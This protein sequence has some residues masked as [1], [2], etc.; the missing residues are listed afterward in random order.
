LTD[1]RVKQIK[2]ASDIVDVVGS[3]INLRPAGP[4]YKGLCPFHDDHRPSLVVDPRWQNYK[5]WACDKYGDVIQFVQEFERV[6]FKEALELLARRA[7]ITL[8]KSTSDAQNLGRA[9]MLDVVRWAA[10]Q[11][12]ECL[13]DSSL[14]EDARRYLG[15]RN[16]KGETVRK[17]ELGFAPRTGDWLV[18]KAEAAKIDPDVL[19]KVSL[20]ARR[21]EGPGFYDR[22]RDRVQFPIR[23]VRGRI[24]GFG[25]RVLPSSPLSERGP[26]YYN[27]SDTPLFSKSELLYGLDQAKAAA[28]KAGYLAV[29]EGYT[30]VL[31][32]HQAGIGQVVA[33]MGTALNAHHVQNL[34]RFAPRVVLVFDA[35]AGGQTGVDRALEIFAG[36]D[37]DLAIATLPA[38][39]D[40]CDLLVQQGPDPFRQ[41]LEKAE[42]ALDFKLR[43]LLNGDSDRGVEGQRRA[44]D[45]VLGIIALAP[46]LP[47]QA[48]A[49]RTQLMVTR[50]SSRLAIREETV[51][52]RLEEMRAQK[53]PVEKSSRA[54]PQ[55][56]APPARS[57]KAVPEERELL[58][59]LLTEEALVAEA[60]ASIQPDEIQ[61]PGLRRLL[62][63]LYALLAEGVP[64][65]L[66]QLRARLL[67]GGDDGPLAQYALNMQEVGLQNDNRA[68][69]FRRLL[70]RFQER[71]NRSAKQKLQ[72][73]LQSTRDH[74][75][76]LDLL[77]RQQLEQHRS[78]E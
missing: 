20:I 21:T 55:V 49:V 4:T 70:V 2:E 40:P 18:R 78:D 5:C 57:S 23:D 42:D 46:P 53:R 17:Y 69:W 59:V 38:G 54:R 30:D 52:A 11:Y 58:E 73:Q 45:A 37:V 16:L 62:V 60:A 34:R 39:L 41:V 1:D 10:Q 76:A 22:F 3:Y 26:K 68:E 14:A 35:D 63:G 64:P 31:M 24:V 65:N 72:T 74:Q 61:H 43:H 32:A 36:Q 71:R 25:G 50:I 15:E 48:G 7:G 19:E 9:L 8:E 66:D 77:R 12:H 27:S 51:W 56:S 33:T 75:A 13:L 29:V 6:D 44:V 47:G 67:Q 28:V